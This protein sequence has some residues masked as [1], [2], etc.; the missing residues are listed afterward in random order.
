[1]CA[2]SITHTFFSANLHVTTTKLF[3]GSS[4]FK[5]TSHKAKGQE[6]TVKVN[7]Q[8]F[9]CLCTQTKASFFNSNKARSK[10][11]LTVNH[12]MLHT[13]AT[14][15]ENSSV[16]SLGQLMTWNLISD[17]HCEWSRLHKVNLNSG[18]SHLK[19][20]EPITPNKLK[21]HLKIAKKLKRT[22]KIPQHLAP[23]KHGYDTDKRTRKFSKKCR[24]W[25]V[26]NTCKLYNFIY[27]IYEYFSQR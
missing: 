27:H 25:H 8:L 17:H 20:R 12:L 1:M 23:A 13:C 4:Y 7:G 26:G 19:V 22:Y 14:Y 15:Q 10:Q 16:D 2:I 24:T 3:K 9:K 6:I 11:S 18:T 21:S 5:N